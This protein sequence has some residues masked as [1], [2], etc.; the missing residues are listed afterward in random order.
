MESCLKYIGSTVG[1][2]VVDASGKGYDRNRRV[3]DGGQVV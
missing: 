3:N 1:K 2:I